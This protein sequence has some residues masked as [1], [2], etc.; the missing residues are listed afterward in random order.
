MRR[1]NRLNQVP[2][3]GAWVLGNIGESELWSDVHVHAYCAALRAEIDE[4]HALLRGVAERDGEVHR[5]R[6]CPDS[7]FQREGGENLA[8]RRIQDDVGLS[9]TRGG[10]HAID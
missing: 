3:E 8:R 7:T 6:G 2:I 1:D 10:G 5:D 4:K 9:R